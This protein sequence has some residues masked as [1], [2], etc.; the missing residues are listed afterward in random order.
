M[1]DDMGDVEG[2]GQQM[3]FIKSFTD[4]WDKTPPITQIYIGSSIGVTLAS[5]LLNKNTW[6]DLLHLDWKPV[7]TGLQIWRPFTAFL[8]FG[9]FGLNY[10]L[11]IHFVW[12]Y[13]AQLEKLNYNKPEEFFMMIMFG[14]V[15]L[16]GGY[17]ILGLSPKFLG[18]NL[19]TYLVYIWARIFEG[20]DVNVMD[21]LVL[22][23]ELLPWFFCAQTLVLEGEFPF[24]DLLGIVVGHLFH[25]L[26]KKKWLTAPSFVKSMFTTDSM[27]K[28]YGKF[29]EDFE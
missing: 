5:M 18:H 9:P 29:K 3:E 16:L 8:F 23:A 14:I 24:A 28:T 26:M 27:K 22:R 1:G 12:T 10:I 15:A 2:G 25:Y 11:T 19:S 4:M 21:L 7:L 20:T 6:P 13:M 17:S